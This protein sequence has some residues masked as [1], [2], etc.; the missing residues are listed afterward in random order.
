MPIEIH[1]VSGR[2]DIKDF[3]RLP[4]GIY[5]G[6]G[7]RW[8]AW[9]P[10][11]D[12]DVRHIFDCKHNPIYH[13]TD[14]KFWMAREDGK[15]VGRIAAFVDRSFIDFQKTRTGFFGF[16][17]CF[18]RQCVARRLL[19]TA[20]EW[21][22]LKGMERCI[23]PVNGSTNFQLGNQ[24]DSFDQMPVI[25]MP[26]SPPF[27]GA[28][29]EGAGYTKA[30]D[31]Y[32]YKANTIENELSEK[33]RRVSKLAAERNRVVIRNGSPKNWEAELT[34]LKKIWE[35]AWRDNWGFTPWYDPEFRVMAKNFKMMMIP[36]LTY[37]AE[38]DGESVGFCLPIPE[39]NCAF[40]KINGK[41]FPTGV[42]HLL[43]AK[44]KAIQ[45]RVAA[46]GVLKKHQNKAI[47]AIMI[48][49][50]FDDA[51]EM[52][53]VHGEFSWIL[54]TNMSLRNLLENWGAGHYRTH[55]VYQ[56]TLEES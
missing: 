11:L 16:F 56:R 7:E 17:E 52:G 8:D 14:G 30:Q 19:E 12:L 22:K 9:V 47:D 51:T 26:Y 34:T 25:G 54:E 40:H 2:R 6:E 28:L 1:P 27:Y 38:I 29:I 49:R 10:P 35:D 41:L 43:T 32:S 21:L 4:Y 3:I 53:I 24:I 36:E 37:I 5:R 20:E 18:N 45:I 50:L 15:V 33:I 44:K 31:L 13:H 23:G 46:L 55:R 48:T 42:F 39:V